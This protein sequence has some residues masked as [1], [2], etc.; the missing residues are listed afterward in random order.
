MTDIINTKTYMEFLN[1]LKK[2]IQQ[3]RLKAHLAVNKELIH[4]YW[5]IGNGILERQKNESWGSKVIEQVSQDLRH[6]FPEMKGL[7]VTNLKYMRMFA[8]EY[9]FEEIS[10]QSVDQLPWGHHIALFTIQNKQKRI[11]Y[12]QNTIE[13]GWSRNVLI[14]WI[15]SELHKR[16]GKALNN[17]AMTLPESQSDLVRESL[18]DPYCLDFLTLSEEAQE[19]EIEQGLIEHLQKELK[20]KLPTVA[21]IETELSGKQRAKKHEK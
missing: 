18:K 2:E 8:G 14:M 17:F 12:I 1:S 7:S 6:S 4:L 15:E 20:G 10:Q 3:V 13:N 21:E 19:K 5:K 9:S 16:K 11:W